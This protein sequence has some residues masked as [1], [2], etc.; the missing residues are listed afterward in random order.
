LC[1]NYANPFTGT[2]CA[3]DDGKKHPAMVL[4][5]GSEGGN[6]MAGFAKRFAEH[7]YVAA[8]VAYFKMPGLPQMLVD[9]PVETILP[10]IATLQ[11]R[12]DVKADK[13]GILGIS[14]GGEFALLAASTYP[15]IKAVVA[16]VPS[17]LAYMGL[18]ES[19]QPE[20]CSWTRG[21]KELPCVPAD[22]TAGMAIGQEIAAQKPITLTPFYDAARNADPLVTRKAMF[23]LEHINGPILCLSGKDDAMWNSSAQCDIAMQYLKA[24][25]HKFADQSDSYPSAG[26]M[27]YLALNGPSSA[28]IVYP[29]PGGA[30]NFGGTPQGDVDAATAAWKATWEFLASALGG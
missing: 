16:I 13:I 10:A 15:Q 12:A 25:H 21:G 18:N 1:A 24:H 19:D 23:P 27:F 7:G 29:F 3:P 6:S 5:G 20:G 2:L 11:S 4:L 14:K 17:P 30:F 26:H 22:P 8:S 9:V 28:M